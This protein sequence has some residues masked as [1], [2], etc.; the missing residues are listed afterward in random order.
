[1]VIDDRDV[2]VVDLANALRAIDTWKHNELAWDALRR[3][4]SPRIEPPPEWQRK[5]HELR[6]ILRRGF[7]PVHRQH[8]WEAV[9]DF[10][11]RLVEAVWSS[12]IV[13]SLDHPAV[14][15]LRPAFRYA[16]LAVIEGIEEERKR[17]WSRGKALR[18]APGS[19][20]RITERG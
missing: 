19:G 1:L 13:I 5:L 3:F 20:R 6:P 18:I 12:G 2:A 17:R 11:E 15:M 4:N 7:D 8:Y 9:V 14:P 10:D 16:W